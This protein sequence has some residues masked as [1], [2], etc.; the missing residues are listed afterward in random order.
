MHVLLE[1]TLKNAS[2]Y[3]QNFFVHEY[4]AKGAIHEID[5][6]VKLISA[7]IFVLLAVSTFEVAKLAF[8]LSSLLI[9][10][11]ILGLNLKKILQR[12]WIF[13]A[14]SFIVVSPFL[15][16]NPSYPFLFTLRVLISLIAVQMVVMSTNFYDLCSSLKALRIPETFVHA[17]WIAYHYTILLFQD[18]INIVLA[19]ESRRVAKTSHREL[20]RKGGEAVGLF[21]LRNL[22]RSERIQLAMISRGEKIVVKKAKLGTLEISY[23]AIVA[24][25]AVWWTML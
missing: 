9:T 13:G 7:V 2:Y 11:I 19:R 16:S 17:L 20:W 6:R 15:L 5:A 4:R 3:F 24:F 1:R 12:I 25:I 21:L 10:S 18:I 14:F 22:E 23:I 8:L